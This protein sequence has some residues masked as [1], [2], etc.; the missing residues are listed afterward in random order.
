MQLRRIRI[1]RRRTRRRRRRRRGL[2]P[3]QIRMIPQFP[4][5]NFMSRQKQDSEGYAN[6]SD[7]HVCDAEEWITAANYGDGR[8]DDTFRAIKLGYV[9]GYVSNMG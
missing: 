1:S 2:I 6:T 7:G 9:V 8:D 4:W 3:A 5:F